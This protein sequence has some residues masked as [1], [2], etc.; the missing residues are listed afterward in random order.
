MKTAEKPCMKS[1]FKNGLSELGSPRVSE[2]HLMEICQ[3][4]AHPWN[5]LR[6]P[7]PE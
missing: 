5:Y 4:T 7:N 2:R 3:R 1:V 6:P